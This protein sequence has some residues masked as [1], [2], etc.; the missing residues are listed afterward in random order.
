MQTIPIS[1]NNRIASVP[2]GYYVVADNDEW[3]VTLKFD[4]EWSQFGAKG[5]RIYIG[6][7]YETIL[8]R[9]DRFVLPRLPE[10]IDEISIGVFAWVGSPN[11]SPVYASSIV[12]LPVKQSALLTTS[13]GGF[14]PVNPDVILPAETVSEDDTVVIDDVSE[15]TKAL[16]TIAQIVAL[17][18]SSG[19][20]MAQLIQALS[21]Y[22]TAAEQDTIDYN[23][24][25]AIAGKYTLPVGGI[26]KSN[27]ASS[28]QASLDKADTALQ[29]APVSSVNGQTGAV[30]LS[31]PSTAQ[32]VGAL[33]DSTVFVSS[34]NGNSGAVTITAAGIG[35]A[36][37]PKYTTLTLAVA[38]WQSSGNAYGCSKTVTGMTATSIV[39]LEYSDTETEFTEAQ[40]AN[41]L[42][43]MV[44][45]LPSAAITVNVAFMEGS[46]L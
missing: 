7:Q 2:P 6:E 9:N 18:S 36:T 10:D 4:S 26:P 37:T 38:D 23:L 3:E 21:Y 39:W 13:G 43:F 29:S 24:S 34:V 31:I 41:T 45:S 19:I 11:D 46:A 40:S 42:T 20:T 35:A 22:R 32:D 1:I 5:A 12:K 28:V 14:V 30:T 33:P 25:T 8:F 27:L 15:G 17:A 16:A 44:D